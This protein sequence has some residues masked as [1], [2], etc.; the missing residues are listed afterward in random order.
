MIGNVLY[1]T[2]KL[3]IEKKEQTENLVNWLLEF[4]WPDGGWNSDRTKK[5]KISSF[6]ETVFPIKGLRLFFEE[7]KDNNIK[8]VTTVPS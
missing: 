7:T 2:Q 6:M 5:A 3:G 1:Y 8:K 4:Q